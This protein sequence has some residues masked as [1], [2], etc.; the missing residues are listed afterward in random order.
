MDSK[1]LFDYA[2]NTG[3]QRGWRLVVKRGFDLVVG[4]VLL[5]LAAPIMGIAGL[6]IW[7][8]D[9]RPLLYR[10]HVVGQQGKPFLSWKFRTMSRDADARKEQLMRHNEML[11]PVFKMRHDP[12]VTRVGRVLRRYSLDELPQIWSV[13]KGDMSLVGPRPPLVTEFER[14]EPWQKRKLSVIPGLTCLWQVQGRS[15]IKDFDEWVQ[16]DLNYIDNW[17]LSLDLKILS[18]TLTTVVLGRGAY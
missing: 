14:F 1:S 16:M 9:G 2:A 8:T 11:G 17:S 12:R 3:R 7:V 15:D 4:S 10:W 18:Q 13:L 6:A 5:T